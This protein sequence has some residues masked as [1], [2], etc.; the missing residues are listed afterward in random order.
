MSMNTILDTCV[1]CWNMLVVC[2]YAV[3]L[4]AMDG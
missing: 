2:E 1:E 3:I 4:S